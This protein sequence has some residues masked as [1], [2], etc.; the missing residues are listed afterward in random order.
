MFSVP[1]PIEQ[2]QVHSHAQPVALIMIPA[3]R[4]KTIRGMMIFPFEK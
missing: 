1:P 4:R 2:A 3:S